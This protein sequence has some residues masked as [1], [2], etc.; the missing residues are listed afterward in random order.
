M[1]KLIRVTSFDLKIDMPESFC[2]AKKL[3]STIGGTLPD[4]IKNDSSQIDCSIISPQA[5]QVV[6]GMTAQLKKIGPNLDLQ[7]HN[8]M[9]RGAVWVITDPYY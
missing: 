8:F 5:A 2:V 9:R 6:S 3:Y 1:E 7:P 4:W